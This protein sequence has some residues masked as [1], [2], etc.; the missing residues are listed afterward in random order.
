MNPLYKSKNVLVLFKEHWSTYLG[1][2]NL[3]IA[4][5]LVFGM[6]I[7]LEGAIL[8]GF[9]EWAMVKKLRRTSCLALPNMLEE[10]LEDRVQSESTPESEEQK[11]IF[12]AKEFF[13]LVEEFLSEKDQPDGLLMI[14]DGYIEMLK[15]KGLYDKPKPSEKSPSRAKKSK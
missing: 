8:D 9:R 14:F 2:L 12:M 5:A 3:D 11:A 7:A 1:A 13:S 10:Y 6:D 4:Y 15:R